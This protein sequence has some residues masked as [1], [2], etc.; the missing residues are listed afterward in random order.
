M[1]RD[2]ETRLGDNATKVRNLLRPLAFAQGQ[3]LPW[4]DIWA[5]VASRA[6][7]TAYSDEDLLWLREHAGS[8]VVDR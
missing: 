2:L 8:Y 7:G 1:H 6:A 5:A 4:E 3:G